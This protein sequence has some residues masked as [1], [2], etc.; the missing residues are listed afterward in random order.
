[1]AVDPRGAPADVSEARLVPTGDRRL[2]G[3]DAAR[4][5]ALLGMMATHVFPPFDAPG[6]SSAAYLVASGRAAALF[7]VLAGVGLALATGGTRRPRGRSWAAAAAGLT[8]RGLAIGL[9][10]LLLGFSGTPVAVILPYYAVLFLLAVPLIGLPRGVVAALAAAAALLVPVVSHALRPGLA[11]PDRTNP[12]L[13]RLGDPLA[14]L[15]ELLVTGYYPA[16]AWVAYLGAGLA[17]GR[18]TLSS[19]KVA[20]ALLAGGVTLAAAA[21]GVS[22]LLIYRFGGQEQ[23]A[24]SVPDDVTVEQVLER[25]Q[26]GSTPTDTWW[27]L[28]VDAPHSTTPLDLLH[29]V[30]TSLAVLGAA[31]LLARVARPA[32]VPLAAAGAMTLSIYTLHVLLLASPLLPADPVTSY[33]GQAVAFLLAAVALRSVGAR[34][35]LEAGVAAVA[36]PVRR[37][38]AAGRPAEH[39]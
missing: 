25:T 32:L 3:V 27:W 7:A 24:A 11:D 28:A 35:P 17:V 38:V 2:A 15:S 16:L 29:T 21:R 13:E 10:G 20:A 4:G 26:Y 39:T 18:L 34:G 37:A 1:V 36:A 9:I 8:V 31:L 19:P 6:D 12:S 22:R 14:L 5:V 33:L 30:G 23:L